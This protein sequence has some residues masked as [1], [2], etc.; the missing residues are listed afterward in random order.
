MDLKKLIEKRNALI[1]EMSALADTAIKEER[2]FTEEE[3]ASYDQKK[4]EVEALDLT[5]G[6]CREQR[7]V[8]LS[9]GEVEE[10]LDA[11]KAEERSF[12]EYIKAKANNT[13][14]RAETNLTTGANG[15]VIPTSIANKII[16][17]IQSI[18]PVYSM[19]DR[20][21]VKGKLSIPYYDE[22]T[23]AIEVA[24]AT[25]FAELESTSGK[26]LSVELDGFL[27]GALTKISKSLI[28]NSK[29]DL[30]SYIVSKLAHA[31]SRWIEK[32]L[33]V[34]TSGKIEGLSGIKNI[35]TAA[36]ANVITADELIDV[37][38]AVIDEYQ[39]TAIWIMSRK[40]RAAIRKLKDGDGPYL[41]QKGA[42]SKW[43][44]SLFG[45][46]VYTSDNMPEI[47]TGKTAIYYGDMSGLA[48]KVSEDLSIEV[49]R[50]KFATQHAVGVLGYVEI[51]AKVEN[52]QKLSALKMA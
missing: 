39:A 15:A 17:L 25:E 44:Y 49:L 21:T 13:E 28:N 43:G 11:V 7:N 40:T 22:T 38:E 47:E 33:L 29:F 23:S 14:V 52:Q 46:P 10:K 16:D 32:Q 24:Y 35:I 42:T 18:C 36:S 30:I 9:E 2:A 19:A 6:R 41:L 8:E 26:F 27:A 12:V 34:G 4:K 20:Y 48:V 51:D 45:K 1:E 31:F 3:T 50:E 37:Q 5:I